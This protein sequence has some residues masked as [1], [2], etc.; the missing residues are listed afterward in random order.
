VGEACTPLLHQHCPPPPVWVA[1]TQVVLS[2]TLLHVSHARSLMEAVDD[3]PELVLNT[4]SLASEALRQ[5]RHE[6]AAL[7]LQGQLYLVRGEGEEG[8]GV[9]HP[10][11]ARWGFAHA[12]MR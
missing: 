6:F 10:A 7:P 1:Q 11:L 3:D 5:F 9:R 4:L 8:G 2:E 12:V